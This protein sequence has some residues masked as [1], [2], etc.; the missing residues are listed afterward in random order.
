MKALHSGQRNADAEA[1]GQ[2]KRQ[3]SEM[4][5]LEDEIARLRV[6]TEAMWELMSE[7]TGL[8]VEQLGIRIYEV[9]MDD[10]RADGRKT[11]PMVDCMK[12][13]AKIDQSDKNCT[14]CGEPAPARSPFAF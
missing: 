11:H 13:Q 7:V 10:G 6:I 5:S 3:R 1:L 9:D 4:Q 14:Y 12:C 8:T 2:R